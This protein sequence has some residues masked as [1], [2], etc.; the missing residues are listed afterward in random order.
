[1]ANLTLPQMQEIV[2]LLDNP[3]YK[4]VLDAL[5]A[6]QDDLLD[7]INVAENQ[8]VETAKVSEWRAARQIFARLNNIPQGIKQ[9]FEE[10]KER[11]GDV[12]S[13]TP[14]SENDFH[15][16]AKQLGLQSN[17]VQDYFQNEDNQ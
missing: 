2:G 4:L 17:L 16:M 12:E 6:Y 9:A 15:L 5:K 13:V 10:E 8:W 14:S 1:M 7:E 11:L 3:G